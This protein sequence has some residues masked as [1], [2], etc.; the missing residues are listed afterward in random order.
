MIDNFFDT[1]LMEGIEISFEDEEMLVDLLVTIGEGDEFY[2]D[3]QK[4]FSTHRGYA[5]MLTFLDIQAILGIDEES[6]GEQLAGGV[7]ARF[8]E[9]FDGHE[10]ALAEDQADERKLH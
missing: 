3:E 2:I 10:E 9:M 8:E 6:L 7:I 4:V 1:G 5:V